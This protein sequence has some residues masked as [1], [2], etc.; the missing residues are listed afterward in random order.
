MYAY[1]CMCVYVCI[2]TYVCLYICADKIFSYRKTCVLNIYDFS[3]LVYTI[4]LATI[5]NY[6]LFITK[7]NKL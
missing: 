4:L 3:A 7:T 1:T 6:N 2:Y 5:L